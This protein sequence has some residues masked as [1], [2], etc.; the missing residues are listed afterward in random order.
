MCAR[1]SLHGRRIPARID[2]RPFFALIAACLSTAALAAQEPLAVTWQAPQPLRGLLQQF[3]KPPAVEK[4]ER[5]AA[6]IRPWIRD[7]RKRVPEIA[8]SE[9]YF[10][11]TVEIEFDSAAR[12]HATVTVTPGPR[13]TVDGVD[14]EFRGDLASGTPQHEKRREALRAGF[15][16]KR[17][18][19]FRSPDWEVAKTKLVESLRDLD[20]AAGALEESKATVDAEQA[21][22]HLHLVLESGPP[23]TLDSE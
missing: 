4:G 18:Q 21:T 8:A 7:V 2:V 22:A 6:S 14:I 5:R 9:G 3:L 19:P 12:D 1:S 20:Y 16:M 23:F 13:T 15:G 11:A 17:G 10:S